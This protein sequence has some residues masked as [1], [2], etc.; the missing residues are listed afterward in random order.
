MIYRINTGVPYGRLLREN[1]GGGMV[2]GGGSHH[3]LTR[4]ERISQM[5]IGNESKIRRIG[6]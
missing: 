4:I 2:G 1:G 6:V 3:E 5:R